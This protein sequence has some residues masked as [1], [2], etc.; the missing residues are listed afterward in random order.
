MLTNTE[1]LVKIGPVDMVAR[2]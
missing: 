2:R 1:N